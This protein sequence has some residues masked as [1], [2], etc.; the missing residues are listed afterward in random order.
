MN[1][2]TKQPAP[3]KPTAPPPAPPRPESW[4]DIF[5]PQEFADYM[6]GKYDKP[7]QPAQPAK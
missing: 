3:T 2:P 1:E 4:G 5:D 7:A 6:A